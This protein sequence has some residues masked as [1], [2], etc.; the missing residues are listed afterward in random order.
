MSSDYIP[1]NTIIHKLH[2]AT[3]LIFWGV[4]MLAMMV[5]DDPIVMLAVL[6][7]TIVM[8][9]IAKIPMS[10]ILELF[11]VILPATVLYVVIDLIFF[12]Y[13]PSKHMFFFYLVPFVNWIPVTLESLVFTVGAVLKFILTLVSYRLIPLTT[14][15][16]DIIRFFAKIRVPPYVNTAISS[17]LA[18]V[19][20]MYDEARTIEEAQRS[21]GLRL[22]YRNPI[23]K[24][25]AIVTLFV[26]LLSVSFQR[27]MRLAVALE[28]KGFG[29]AMKKRTYYHELHFHMGDVAFLAA[30]AIISGLLIYFGYWYLNILNYE[31]TV[32]LIESFIR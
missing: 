26:P 31:N 11:K 15:V 30:F 3:K 14:P 8:Y 5:S 2:P 32:R 21:R 29:Y 17:A 25:R 28:S 24:A 20:V 23:K 6:F 22:E 27:S 1:G 12:T 7:G 9:M 4:V 10:K 16:P 13:D 18:Y 19:P